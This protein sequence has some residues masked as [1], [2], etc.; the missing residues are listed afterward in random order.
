MLPLIGRTAQSLSHWLQPAFEEDL[1]LWYDVDQVEA[2]APER[3]K[4]WSR[5]GT[6]DFL[7][8]NEKREAV[9]YGPVDG[10]D[11]APDAVS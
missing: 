1:R 9:G 7:T 2:L 10:G 11:R 5:I 8:V 4:L 6:A 3:E